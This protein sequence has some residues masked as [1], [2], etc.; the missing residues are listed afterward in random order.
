VSETH[1]LPLGRSYIGTRKPTLTPIGALDSLPY[2]IHED[3]VVGGRPPPPPHHARVCST[4]SHT[5]TL[6]PVIS[7]TSGVARDR[8]MADCLN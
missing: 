7:G 8:F 1:A 3:S 6:T 2:K 5:H 4:H